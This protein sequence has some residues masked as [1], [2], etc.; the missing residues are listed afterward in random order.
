M[1]VLCHRPSTTESGHSEAVSGHPLAS[2]RRLSVGEWYHFKVS[3]RLGTLLEKRTRGWWGIQWDD[4]SEVRHS[5]AQFLELVPEK[6]K[7]ELVPAER[8]VEPKRSLKK[9]IDFSAN[10]RVQHKTTGRKG[11]L[12]RKNKSWYMVKWCGTGPQ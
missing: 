3:G 9:L 4:D 11:T 12:E 8:K 10:K 2:S 1:V 7:E 6:R 5:R